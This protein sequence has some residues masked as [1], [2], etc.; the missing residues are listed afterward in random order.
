[1]LDKI[2]VLEKPTEVNDAMD[3]RLEPNILSGNDVLTVNGL[4]EVL[5]FPRH[6]LQT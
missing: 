4:A 3:I 2:E 1:M 6:Y 5:W